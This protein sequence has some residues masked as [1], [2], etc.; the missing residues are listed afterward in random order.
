M[1]SR[2]TISANARRAAILRAALVRRHMGQGRHAGR[3]LQRLAQAI[4]AAH[5]ISAAPAIALGIA[6]H[7]FLSVRLRRLSDCGTGQAGGGG[8]SPGLA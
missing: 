3:L 8:G 5:K 7:R 6:S 4:G 1:S 2:S